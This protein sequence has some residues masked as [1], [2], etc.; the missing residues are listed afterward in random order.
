MTR[1]RS[2]AVRLALMFGLAVTGTAVV[3]GLLLHEFQCRQ[4]RAQMHKELLARYVIVERMVQH[5][6]ST[7]SWHK[8]QDKLTD[9]TPTDGSLQF[10]IT[11]RDA[12]FRFNERFFADAVPLKQE[13]DFADIAAGGDMYTALSRRIAGQEG[14]P[15]VTLAIAISQRDM[16]EAQDALARGI[17]IVSLLS[18]SLASAAGWIIARRGLASVDRLS[19]HA[20]LLGGRDLSL[21]LPSHRLPRELEG[22]VLS[23]NEALERLQRSHTQLSRFNADVAHELRTPVHNLIGETQVTL[24]RPRTA[25]ELEA[26]LQSNLEELERLA[27]IIQ[28]MLFLARVDQGDVAHVLEHASLATEVNKCAEFMEF[29]FEETGSALVVQGDATAA[30]QR[31]LFG[32]AVTNLLDNALRHGRAGGT[33]RV[34]ITQGEVISLAVQSQSDP[35]PEAELERIFDRFYRADNARKDS[36][37]SHGLG[38]SI[39]KAIAAILGGSVFA[40]NIDSGVEIGFTLPGA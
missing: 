8:L 9:F 16:D 18:I 23:L 19:E 38:L 17:I 6:V 5:H 36:V 2:I 10:V 30:I 32:Q 21:R 11:S 13:G 40:R 24:T 1:M 4:L 3:A 28:A 20:T 25:E 7:A 37:R 35:L 27:E 39:V 29:L 34:I 12:G 26:A 22:L 14:R 15:D 31:S 33:V